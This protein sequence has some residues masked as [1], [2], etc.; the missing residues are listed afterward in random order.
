MADPKLNVVI[1]VDGKEYSAVLNQITKQTADVGEKSKNTAASVSQLSGQMKAF[2]GI[3]GA[4]GV[5]NLIKNIVGVNAEFQKLNASLVTVTGST[6]AADQAFAMIEKFAAQTP[7]Q[8]QEVTSAFIKLKALGL[9]AGEDSL[10]SYGN[11][12]SAMGKSLDQMIEAVADAATG[13]FERL[14]EF[15]IKTSVQG[16]NVSFRFK[17]MTTVV[18]NSASEI[19]KYL[20]QIG[21]EDFAGGMARQMDTLD[22]KFS[23]LQDSSAALARSIGKAGL[24]EL[25]GDLADGLNDASTAINAFLKDPTS[26]PDWAKVSAFTLFKLKQEF[27]DLGDV[28]GATAAIL[29]LKVGTGFFAQY[30]AIIE[31]RRRNRDIVETEA[32]QFVAMLEGI[33]KKEQAAASIVPAE[34]TPS[35]SVGSKKSAKGT[36]KKSDDQAAQ[37]YGKY[38]YE[39]ARQ[40]YPEATQSA[41]EYGQ[42]MAKIVVEQTNTA[43]D[44]YIARLVEAERVTLAA[45]T[46]TEVLSDEMVRLN[47]L[48]LAGDISTETYTQSIANAE[49]GMKDLGDSGSDA[50]KELV[51]AS[52]GW[53][54][55]F[56]NTMA[57]MVMSGKISFKSLAESI[58]K[59]LLRIAIYQ[60]ITAPILQGLGLVPAPVKHSGG[61]VTGSGVT[62]N[63]SPLA[64]MGAPRYHSGGAIQGLGLKPGEVPI[65]AQQGESVIPRGGISVPAPVIEINNYT[66]QPVRQE[67]STVDGKAMVR[68]FI[69]EAAADVR[70]GGELGAAITQS[71]GVRRPGARIS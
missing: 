41:E 48:W 25:M 52:K 5:T 15:G 60:K 43:N 6:A 10:R 21:D 20:R 45:R 7:Y 11:T 3:V 9:D 56:T 31:E 68:L 17:G 57:E 40:A 62:R 51:A 22:G 16:D 66:G 23:N 1:T 69:G 19:T 18:Q 55:E 67:Q 71:F 32:Q 2:Y 28:I 13:E 35:P 36:G 58:I 8:L 27:V 38:M 30:D 47:G 63:V 54:D 44:A 33:G 42:A 26:L 53:G 4:A 64:F 39:L 70:R 59:D 34:P 61:P 46:A 65:I 29:N 12:A 14:K 49:Q 37:D 50:F 24:N